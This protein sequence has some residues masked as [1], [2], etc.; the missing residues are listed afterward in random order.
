[1]CDVNAASRGHAH[2]D[3]VCSIVGGGPVPVERVL[4]A[5][6]D[7]FIK[8]VLHDGTKIQHVV[9]YGRR[10]NAMQRTVLTLGTPPEHPR[11][12]SSPARRGLAYRA[13]FPAALPEAARGDP[14][15]ALHSSRLTS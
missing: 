3:E 1:M 8:A 13:S 9:H 11:A 2:S 7:A 5:A 12:L 6:R 10:P 15:A 14:L 4:V